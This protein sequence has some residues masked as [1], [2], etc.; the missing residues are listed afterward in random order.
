MCETGWGDNGDFWSYDFRMILSGDK[1]EKNGVGILLNKVWELQ[2]ENTYHVND[3]IS[4]IK[5]KTSTV[6][7]IV[8]QVYFPTS[9]SRSRVVPPLPVI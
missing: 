4:L 3:R 6:N 1:Q 9:N 7:M 2:V 5:L 8:I